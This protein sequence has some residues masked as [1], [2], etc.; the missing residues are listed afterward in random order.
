MTSGG[1]TIFIGV[2]HVPIRRGRAPA[3][4]KNFG[5]PMCAKMVWPRSRNLWDRSVFL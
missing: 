2:N 4:R 3:S 5:T 1:R